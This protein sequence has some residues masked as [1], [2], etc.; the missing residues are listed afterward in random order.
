VILRGHE[1]AVSAVATSSDS[2][3]V[4]TESADNTARLWDLSA[5]DSAAKPVVLRGHG[6]AISTVAISPDNHWLVTGSM[7]GT[8][9]L[10][11]LSSQ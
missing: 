4:V 9:R 11:D 10:W 6:G 1:G 8:S 2:R 3:W 7:D 5:K